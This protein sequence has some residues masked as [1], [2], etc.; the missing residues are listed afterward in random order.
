LIKAARE[1]INND[2]TKFSILIAGEGEERNNLE[3]LIKSL[4]LDNY[5]EILGLKDNILELMRE[6]DMYIITS[7]YEGVSI[8]MIEAMACGLPIISSSIR[9]IRDCI[10]HKNNGMLYPFG[11]AKALSN[12]VLQIAND[13][14]LKQK[15]SYEARKYYEKEYDM[16]QN[17]RVLE[18]IYFKALKHH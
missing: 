17:I 14:E 3:F 12:C 8:A 11:D 18:S 16:N 7:K 5:V 4:Q 1:L 15:L 10:Q 2:F 9:S 6:V 13:I